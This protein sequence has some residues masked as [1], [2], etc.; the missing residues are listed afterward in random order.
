MFFGCVRSEAF[1]HSVVSDRCFAMENELP[2]Y[3]AVVAAS[4][5]I[6]SALH[7][8]P[9]LTCS[10][11]DKRVGAGV[12]LFFKAEHLQKT[13]SFK[14][15]GASNAMALLN[16]SQKRRGVVTHS[17]GNHAAALAWAAQSQRVAATVVMP[18]N[19]LANK[20]AAVRG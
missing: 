17:S 2:D 3:A 12:Q 1:V 7:R 19:S 8:T 13:G 10:S 4:A 18:E 9:V 11:L 5:R 14:A 16:D 20:I 15:R 6:K